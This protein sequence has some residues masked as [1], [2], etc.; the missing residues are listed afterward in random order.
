[1]TVLSVS[2]PFAP[3]GPDA[4]GGSEQVLA[5]LDRALTEAGH[6]SI[7][8]APA[9]SKVR[10][11]H[12]ATPSIVGK[13]DDALR[14]ELHTATRNAIL[15]TLENHQVDVVHMHGLDF[16]KYLP[17][18]PVP[19]LAT[20]HLPLSWYPS[21]AVRPCRPWTF[22]HGV[23]ESQHRTRP[24]GVDLLPPIKNGVDLNEF[25]PRTRKLDFAMFLG[26]ICPEKGVDTALRACRQAGLPLL[27]GGRVY[28]YPEHER[29]FQTEVQPLLDR[30]RRFLGP[31]QVARKAAL[32]A[33]ARCLIVPSVA[34]ET[35]SLVA[36]EAL[37][38]GTP[39]VAYP[40]GAIPEVVDDGR[41]GFLVDSESGIASAIHRVGE[42][43]PHECRRAAVDRFDL[44]K[45]V[46]LYFQRY[47]QLK[48]ALCERSHETEGCV[49]P[50]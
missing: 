44:R 23:S 35:S 7:V 31:L 29:Y 36:M 19:V 41:T 43:S 15:R 18:P 37:A 4:V 45:T 27:I 12:V 11:T 48:H 3:V 34:P 47:R 46:D 13:I 26:R 38:C 9:D 16:W 49:L 50:N 33:A 22:L 40:S 2:Y 8:V 17:P 10:G 30:C 28:G 25:Q 1:M 5:A 6:R 14:A 20:L 39:V 24:A 32:L 21:Q 42:I